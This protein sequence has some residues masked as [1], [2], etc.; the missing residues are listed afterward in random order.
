M[1][2]NMVI[3]TR[4]AVYRWIFTTANDFFA[5]YE[6]QPSVDNLAS[7]IM[8]LLL[9]NMLLS[10]IQEVYLLG[11]KSKNKKLSNL[12]QLTV[13]YAVHNDMPYINTINV[14]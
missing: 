4:Y 9:S 10:K 1:F 13:P 12:S 14:N 8:C 2:L 3:L 11:L 5:S 7:T 6:F